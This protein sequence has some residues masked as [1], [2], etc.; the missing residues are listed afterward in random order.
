MTLPNFICVGV[1][2]AGTTWLYECLKEHPEVYV[3]EVKELNFFSS[4]FEKG[5]EYYAS[6]FENASTDYKAIGE[7]SP[8]YYHIKTAIDRISSTL[9]NTKIILILR[10]P[11]ARSYSHYQLSVTNQCSGMTFDEA[12]EQVPI[13]STLSMQATFV[14]H[15]LNSFPRNNI[16]LAFYDELQATPQSFLKGVFGFLNVN[17]SFTPSILNNR[18]NRI[19]FPRTQELL[20]KLGLSKLVEYIKSGWLGSIIKENYNTGGRKKELNVNNAHKGKFL[21]DIERLEDLLQIELSH[22]KNK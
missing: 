9:P 18:V 2:R 20:N 4:H 10:E 19:I 12:M 8:N 13:I 3:P 17:D 14:E 1:Q 22:W 15:I 5:I 7:L 16:H 21:D 6:F 11:V